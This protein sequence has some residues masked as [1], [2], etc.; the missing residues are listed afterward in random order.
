MEKLEEILGMHPNTL[1]HIMKN[2]VIR[3]MNAIRRERANFTSEAKAS[4][5][6]KANDIVT[7]ADKRAQKI[8]LEIFRERLPDLGIIAE[9]ENLIIPHRTKV[10]AYLTIDPLDG[11]AAF[12][13]G[14]T[15]GTTTMISLVIGKEVVAAFVADIDTGEVFM[16]WP[17]A[18]KVQL[19]RHDSPYGETLDL[20]IDAGRALNKQYVLLRKAPSE[21]S[22]K[23]QEI[24]SLNGPEALFKGLSVIAGG[25]GFSFNQILKGVFGALLLEK[26]YET[27]WDSSPVIGLAKKLGFKFFFIDPENGKNIREIC[28]KP[29]EKIYKRD[30]EI[31]VIHESRKKEFM[32]WVRKNS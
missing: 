17:G 3:A 18:D 29:I 20:K 22:A 11:T 9:E 16:L 4:V 19:Y 5:T 7:S 30:F 21:Y 24:I 12:A 27:P 23:A 32:D 14:Q 10:K 15:F 25:I 28:P 2:A 31:L 13:R 26:S 6:G 1:G 8:Y